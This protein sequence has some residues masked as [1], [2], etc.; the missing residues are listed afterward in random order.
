MKLLSSKC[1][2]S[3]NVN[4]LQLQNCEVKEKTMLNSIAKF[5]K[6]FKLI[7]FPGHN[8]LNIVSVPI[9]VD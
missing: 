6:G 3:K 2:K 5:K 8:V 9:I 1:L 7:N 4:A